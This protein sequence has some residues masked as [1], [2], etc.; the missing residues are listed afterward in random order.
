VQDAAA[1]Y[2][3]ARDDHTRDRDGVL[4]ALRRATAL[5]RGNVQYRLEL[6]DALAEQGDDEAARQLLVDIRE[7]APE[8][9]DVNMRL[10]RLAARGGHIDDATRY[11][12]N[13]IHGVW[14][15]DEEPM[16][17]L[18]RLE[19][20]RYLLAHERRGRALAELIALSETLPASADAQLEIASLLREAGD[21]ARALALFRR[22]LERDDANA[23]A[24]EG[25]GIAAFEAGDYAATTRYVRGLTQLSPRGREVQAIAGF[26]VSRNPLRRGLTADERRRRM[27]SAIGTVLDRLESCAAGS[28]DPDV[29]GELDRL[30]G[31]THRLESLLRNRRSDLSDFGDGLARLAAIEQRTAFCGP[32]PPADEA[33]LILARQYEAGQ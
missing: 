15:D 24:R 23:A 14:R 19:L 32:S 4:E 33:L 22:V 27:R 30:G 26:V 9:P 8:S 18:L 13:A 6:A 25:A 16:P 7:A 20:I 31:E 10:A 1:W 29:R 5:D 11:Y 28:S 21:P 17:R 3:L 12:Q 2:A